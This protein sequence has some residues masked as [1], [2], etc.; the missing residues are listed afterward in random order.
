MIISHQL[1]MKTM[2]KYKIIRMRNKI[3]YHAFIKN[4]TVLE[5][6]VSKIYESY[7]DLVSQKVLE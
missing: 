3:S 5:L 2:L 1:M 6:Y 7:K 4:M